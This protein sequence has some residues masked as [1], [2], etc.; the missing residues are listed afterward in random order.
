MTSHSGAHLLS[1]LSRSRPFRVPTYRQ[2]A[3]LCMW[4]DP[5]EFQWWRA[6]PAGDQQGMQGG[7][8]GVLLA[9]AAKSSPVVVIPQSSLHVQGVPC[10]SLDI[11]KLGAARS[12]PAYLCAAV[13]MYGEQPT[14]RILYELQHYYD[15]TIPCGYMP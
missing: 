7:V 9:T 13:G 3:H 10:T 6:Q 15:C 2:P 1:I 8:R 12:D 5:E 11:P 4:C 14:A